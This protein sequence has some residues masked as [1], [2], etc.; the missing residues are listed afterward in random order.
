MNRPD[1][2]RGAGGRRRY[3]PDWPRRLDATRSRLGRVFLLLGMA[4]LFATVGLSLTNRDA[5]RQPLEFR[6][7]GWYLAAAGDL[8]LVA[9]DRVIDGD[10][11][12]VLALQTGIRVRAFGFDAPER[13][14]RCAAEATAR[15]TA[16]ATLAGG[17]LRL[18]PDERLQDD[19]G[20]ELR[21]LFTPNG[22]SIDAAMVS[23]GL[24]TAWRRDGALRDLLVTRE[25][26]AREAHRGCLWREG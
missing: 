4:I 16:L 5:T 17:G 9:L 15:L 10:T 23:E 11:V 25:D 14:E 1:L 20:R 22:W 3:V 8:P 2:P 12:D 24:A 26:E 18:M 13:D 6:G 21:Y 19:D 7:D